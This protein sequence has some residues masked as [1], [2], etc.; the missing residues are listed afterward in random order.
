M[1]TLN[2]E[3]WT[4]SRPRDAVQYAR[5]VVITTFCPVVADIDLSSTTNSPSTTSLSGTSKLLLLGR[6]G[7]QV[8]RRGKTF[9]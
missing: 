5:A 6:L 1:N 9:S 4:S 8:L 2:E 3:S 7:P